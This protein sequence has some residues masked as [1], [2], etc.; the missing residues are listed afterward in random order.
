MHRD[1]DVIIFG[2]QTGAEEGPKQSM[3]YQQV[4][5]GTGT[6]GLGH[7]KSSASHKTTVLLHWS[8]SI[9]V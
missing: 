2:Q 5:R 6:L 1:G 7:G 4:W 3:L 8:S 9:V